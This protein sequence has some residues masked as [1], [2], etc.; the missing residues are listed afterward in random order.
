M[1][2]REIENLLKEYD[3]TFQQWSTITVNG[4]KKLYHFI[5]RH[6]INLNVSEDNQFEFAFIIPH[7]IFQLQCPQCS[8]FTD[9]EHFKKMYRKFRRIVI[10]EG[11]YEDE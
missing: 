11:W 10:K 8:P 1:E 3:T 2:L 5:D 4:G 7:T 6:G 9:K